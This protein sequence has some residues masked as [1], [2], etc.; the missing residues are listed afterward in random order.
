[1]EVVA[2]AV[3]TVCKYNQRSAIFGSPRQDS[4]AANSG[5]TE[6]LP[7]FGYGALEYP[8]RRYRSRIFDIDKAHGQG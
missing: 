8:D 6:W 3:D 4:D 5:H 2:E 7:W 1:M